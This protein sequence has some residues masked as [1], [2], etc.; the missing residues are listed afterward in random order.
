MQEPEEMPELNDIKVDEPKPGTKKNFTLSKVKIVKD[1]GL[2]VHYDAAEAAGNEVYI[3][4][5]HRTS[6]KDIHPDLKQL[7]KDL[8]PI[9]ARVF[10]L[11]SFL[12]MVEIKEFKATASQKETARQ[13]GD[14]LINKVEVRGISL[15]G[16]DANYGVVITAVLEVLNGQKTAINTP[17]IK[18]AKVT[19]G[20]EE[21][22]EE[23][24]DKIKD[25]VYLFLFKGKKAQL[26]L[27]GD[28]EDQTE[29]RTA[30]SQGNLF[31]PGENDDDEDEEKGFF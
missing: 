16:K 3:D 31:E 21:E 4:N 17:I 1:G 6:A 15:S 26:E 2:D 5:V 28:Y 11:T 19:H 22:L 23:I 30:E 27:F 29:Q 13:L 18:F 7:F 10:G 14:E 24:V 20:F 12:S 8:S 9:V 25:E